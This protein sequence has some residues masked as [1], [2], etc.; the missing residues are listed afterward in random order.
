M[1]PPIF[2]KELYTLREENLSTQIL[3]STNALVFMLEK[4][5]AEFPKQELALFHETE[6]GLFYI[7]VANHPVGNFVMKLHTFKLTDL[8]GKHLMIDAILKLIEKLKAQKI[9][10]KLKNKVLIQLSKE[11]WEK[12]SEALINRIDDWDL[13]LNRLIDFKIKE[14]YYEENAQMESEDLSYFEKLIQQQKLKVPK[15]KRLFLKGYFQRHFE[16]MNLETLNNLL[17][18]I[19]YDSCVDSFSTLLD[20]CLITDNQYQTIYNWEKTKNHNILPLI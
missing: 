14:K 11:D 8:Q 13:F 4:K 2:L 7:S 6:H 12:N 16:K 1:T 9:K 3:R 17:Y 15:K 20:Y 10:T 5:K 18:E 19:D